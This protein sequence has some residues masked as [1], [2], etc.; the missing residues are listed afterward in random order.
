[1]S[2][3]DDQGAIA[4]KHDLAG[5]HARPDIFSLT[6]GRR[7]RVRTARIDGLSVMDEQAVPASDPRLA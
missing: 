3:R 5:D 6:A 1:M 4:F 7:S 2:T